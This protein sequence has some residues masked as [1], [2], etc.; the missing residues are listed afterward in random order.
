MIYQ[1]YI[2]KKNELESDIRKLEDEWTLNKKDDYA[3]NVGK[4]YKSSSGLEFGRIV[5]MGGNRPGYLCKE[6][7]LDGSCLYYSTDEDCYADCFCRNNT[8]IQKEEFDKM[9]DDAIRN[10]KNGFC[11]EL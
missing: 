9:L 6:I 3:N 5:S 2:N 1:E 10:V 4:Y 8:I 7:S 11:E